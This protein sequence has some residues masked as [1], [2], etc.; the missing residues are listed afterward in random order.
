[1][2]IQVGEVIAV[3]GVKII[4][5][6]DDESSKDTI[7]YKGNKFKG[8]SIREHISIQRGFKDIV[9]I[10]EGEYLDE[11]RYEKDSNKVI[12]IR[13]VEAKPIGYFHEGKFVEGIK[14][15]P[16]IK[17][18][19]FLV[20]ENQVAKIY[21]GDHL[22]DSLVIGNLLKENIPL[23]LPWSRL[24]NTHIGIFGNT[25]SGKSNT[26]AKLYKTLFDLKKDSIKGKSEFVLLDF[27]GEYTADQ[28][29]SNKEKKIYHLSTR[30][31]DSNKF[32]ISYEELL[33]SETLGLL[34]KATPN[35]QLPFI[36]RVVKGWK[37]YR[38]E[39]ES[40]CNYIRYTFKQIFT[41]KAQKKETV[42]LLRQVLKII[43]EDILD[44]RLSQISWHNKNF[45]F[46]EAPDIYFDGTEDPYNK[47]FKASVDQITID[48][49]TFFDEL[50]IRFHLQ[51]IND[52]NAGFVQFDH[53]QPL[54]KRIE[55]SV[56]NLDKVIEINGEFPEEKIL[57]IVSLR[58]CNQEIKKILPLLLAKH[59][60]EKHKL[61]VT[62]PPNKTLHLIIDE[63]HNI[64]SLQSMREQ[65]S[66]KDYRL[67]LFEEIIK[68]G[69]KFGVFLTLSSQ[70]PADISPT[71]M[72][73][74]HNFFI[75]RLVNDKDLFL[76]DNT[77]STLD[78]LSKGMI[79]NLSKG[80]C[81]ITGTSFDLP[82]VLQVD[83]LERSYQPDSEDVDL[84]MVWS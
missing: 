42:D 6:I 14:Y 17:D 41:S 54:L 52:L 38:G 79:P 4:L 47:V 16:M 62:I 60:Y 68:E 71:I 37:K 55:S 81:I 44:Q 3:H 50:V 45:Q 28:L 34:F 51:L 58:R 10:I 83:K 49:L 43:N 46:Y 39:Q 72:S 74:I 70:R 84:E 53:I 2:T 8:I 15:L 75:H 25:G 63:A 57:T 64:L 18:P 82:L 13:K 35:T 48:S 65:E 29:L 69:R 77:I 30:E 67:E 26:L 5:K 27:N 36:K 7:F 12:Y 59:L 66:W 1:M 73:Q 24:F 32:P 56:A 11:S 76:L 21:H 19:V 61:E 80:C 40:L 23:S 33:D 78:S 22:N 9:C 20:S 31:E